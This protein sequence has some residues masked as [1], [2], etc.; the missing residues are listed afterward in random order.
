MADDDQ[1][2]P[3]VNEQDTNPH[4]QPEA[5][6]QQVTDSGGS[7]AWW[8]SAP[9]AEQTQDNNGSNAWW[10]NAPLA[11]DQQAAPNAPDGPFQASQ[12]ESSTMG[13]A[14]RG[15]RRHGLEAA[16]GAIGGAIGFAAGAPAGLVGSLPGALAGGYLGQQ[17]GAKISDIL[18]LDAD[19]QQEAA[20]IQ[21]H[22]YA[23]QLGAAAPAAAGFALGGGASMVTRA[24]S[25]GLGAG[26]DLLAQ[27][28]EKGFNNLD[29][30]ETLIAGGVGAALATPRAGV[31]KAA[32]TGLGKL[33]GEAW[34]TS[35]HGIQTI[36]NP[37]EDPAV[38]AA[39]GKGA[40]EV[41]TP[42][43][44]A[45]NRQG[46]GEYQTP[47]RAEPPPAD[48]NAQQA[49]NVLLG[50]NAP[51]RPEMPGV[52]P[53]IADQLRAAQRISPPE[54]IQ[55][56]NENQRPMDADEGLPHT[57]YGA[58]DRPDLPQPLPPEEIARRRAEL[59]ATSAPVQRS[60][61]GR[62]LAPQAE[63]LV[64]PEIPNENFGGRGVG[65]Q[66]EN[67]PA[68]EQGV[69]PGA[70]RI[71]PAELA[72]R[73]ANEPLKPTENQLPADQGIF[74]ETRPQGELNIPQPKV[75]PKPFEGMIENQ[76]QYKLNAK[77]RA[78]QGG[79]T[80]QI[81]DT[82]G[83]R[84]AQQ[85][86]TVADV[87]A[88]FEQAG[89]EF[90]A[91][92][93]GYE[94]IDPDIRSSAIGR[95]IS[96]GR[97]PLD[98]LDA[99]TGAAEREAIQEEG[100]RP[101]SLSGAAPEGKASDTYG[102]N[103]GDQAK[104]TSIH[105]G[106]LRELG[107]LVK[108]LSRTVQEIFSA[109]NISAFSKKLDDIV[110]AT[111]GDMNAFKQ[112]TMQK[113]SDTM[114]KINDH[115][116]NVTP[117][118]RQEALRGFES[119]EVSRKN[120]LF[121]WSRMQRAA[122]NMDIK[123]MRKA[124]V[125]RNYT[126]RLGSMFD[127]PPVKPGE[128]PENFRNWAD[129]FYQDN[130]RGPTIREIMDRGFQLRGE[131]LDADGSPNMA[132]IMDQTAHLRKQVIEA[133]RI[134][135][136]ARDTF[137]PTGDGQ[138]P[139]MSQNPVHGWEPIDKRLTN[140]MQ[141]YAPREV[142][143]VFE[144][145]LNPFTRDPSVRNLMDSIMRVKNVTNG[146]NLAIDMYH[147]SFMAL[148]G[149]GKGLGLGISQLRADPARGIRTMIEAPFAPYTLARE[150]QRS[151]FAA[152]RD[153]ASV[154]DL[155]QRTVLQA[156]KDGGWVA[157]QRGRDVTPELE[158]G[159]LNSYANGLKPMWAEYKHDLVQRGLK[160]VNAA[161][162]DQYLA[163]A[164]H[165]AM[166]PVEGVVN[167]LQM[168]MHPFFN[169]YIPALKAG[170][171]Y[172]DVAAYMV[173][174]P[175]ESFKNP[176]EA[177]AAYGQVAKRSIK[178]GDNAMGEL[179][180]S[181]MYWPPMLK[182]LGNLSTVSLG[183]NVGNWRQVGNV[184]NSLVR[185][186]GSAFTKSENWNPA[187]NTMV[188]G[189]VMMGLANIFYQTVKTGKPPDSITDLVAGKTGG[190]A[191]RS[192]MPERAILPGYEKDYLEVAHI[193]GGPEGTAKGVKD[194]AYNK[195]AS[196]WR[197]MIDFTNNTD[198]S[199]HTIVDPRLPLTSRMA[200][201]SKYFAGHLLEPIG[202]QNWERGKA[203]NPNT[204]I[205]TP[206]RLVGVRHAPAQWEKPQQ[207]EAGVQKAQKKAVEESKRFHQR[208]G[209]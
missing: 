63:N 7:D 93:K 29:P 142:K 160:S 58:E 155:F 145:F 97:E 59:E 144:R 57:R 167:A 55:A 36:Q 19:K 37:A 180:Q 50:G 113:I 200:D 184:V 111:Q 179:N 30:T 164:G 140:D 183:W 174:H 186:P 21:Q 169:A 176:E 196:I 9:L 68:G 151:V 208:I 15:A 205:S 114:D 38:Q 88:E 122:A 195:L 123:E 188:G 125:E 101:R 177:R 105:R 193:L 64:N 109:E 91:A 46:P 84:L 87:N 81:F 77:K 26:V 162:K 53:D 47:Q 34:P 132:R 206:E 146:I 204:N 60:A 4:P 153:P 117:D 48:L 202:V 39:M 14:L 83:Q 31:L 86:R 69:F 43:A 24:L 99:A 79:G 71:S 56:A 18:G 11:G 152:M 25:A 191:A 207:Y 136:Q 182:Y 197:S 65:G 22:P 141:Y 108:P 40:E 106:M 35:I 201:W 181:T 172:R 209:F 120:P 158:T 112:K 192:Q 194:M 100:S 128:Q 85:G 127:P 72:Q 121:N 44:N 75:A 118:M 124:D 70:E 8:K 2:Q 163:A 89:R 119:G 147:M 41:Q 23:S 175:M 185:N 150:G 104:F 107:D 42:A 5:A 32:E 148:E 52:R 138:Q 199:G 134:F 20:D 102:S 73:R 126:T 161:N 95:M 27:G 92:T 82:E 13:A 178:S 110:K 198:W 12:D 33:A 3:E 154:K 90:D 67:T 187:I 10:K 94:G 16:A 115:I 189:L 166:L 78:E 135:N 96:E 143:L 54:D 61:A 129:Q 51:P 116:Q 6:P 190:K 98:A 66:I 173:D 80:Q 131:F 45:M 17:A 157:R 74:G 130:K 49:Q 203:G 133:N 76:E 170:A 139:L 137:M 149:M 159:F 168:A 156:M 28:T 1:D 171:V 165:A 103:P 62:V